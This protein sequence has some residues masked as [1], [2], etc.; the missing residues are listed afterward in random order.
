MRPALFRFVWLA[1]AITAATMSASMSVQGAGKI[2]VVSARSYASGAATIKVTGAFGVNQAIPINT[3]ASFSDGEMTW[4]QFGDSGSEAPNAL[5]T[6]SPDEIGVSVSRGKQIA[7][8]GGDAC[9]GKM[10][11]TRNSIN[12]NYK[13]LD[14]TSYDPRSSKMSKVNI[15]IVLTAKS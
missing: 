4:L 12:A 10:D 8:A 6:I 3:Q 7:T 15:E 14:V 9:T 5:V 11:V 1:A 13:C 2:P